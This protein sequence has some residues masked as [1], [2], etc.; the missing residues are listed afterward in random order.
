MQNPFKPKTP[1]LPVED[2]IDHAAITALQ[3]EAKAALK[4]NEPVERLVA[5]KTVAESIAQTEVHLPKISV[6]T[7]LPLSTAGKAEIER[8]EKLA[9][10]QENRG[11][12][13]I[14]STAP[15]VTIGMTLI[16]AIVAMPVV[17]MSG[18]GLAAVCL[19]GGLII[20]RHAVAQT[21]KQLLA[22][23]NIPNPLAPLRASVTTA[24]DAI[25]STLSL[26]EARQSDHLD[27]ALKVSPSLR[28][29][30]GE[31]AVRTIIRDDAAAP[32]KIIKKTGPQTR[33]P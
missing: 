19:A 30:F 2:W 13:I 6:V 14:L 1:A 26:E 4:I 9:V 11:A 18:F 24:I 17:A 32:V 16:G 10:A 7:V 20:T 27:A 12:V 33:Q 23:R 28:I 29:R 3:E 25:E 8:L 22:A 21:K 5:L 15:I 31:E